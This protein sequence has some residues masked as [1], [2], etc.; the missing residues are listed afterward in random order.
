MFSFV[1]Y[2]YFNKSNSI[3][4]FESG[5][6]PLSLGVQYKNESPGVF[7][8]KKKKKPKQPST[9]SIICSCANQQ[10]FKTYQTK[11]TMHNVFQ[12]REKKRKKKKQKKKSK[13]FTNIRNK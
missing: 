12:M 1:I 13:V 11:T 4:N 3:T 2:V 10:T 7:I 6:Q 5:V 9:V 8:K